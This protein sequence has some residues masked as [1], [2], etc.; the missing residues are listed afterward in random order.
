MGKD[1]ISFAQ[2]RKLPSTSRGGVKRLKTVDEII[3]EVL[4]A[5]S[6][7]PP[8]DSQTAN[9]VLIMESRY[10]LGQGCNNEYIAVGLLM[11]N[12][13]FA[14]VVKIFIN[15]T[16]LL[17]NLDS[18]WINMEKIF[19]MGYDD[20]LEFSFEDRP[21]Y[22]S[23]GDY[24]VVGEVC[25]SVTSGSGEVLRVQQ[26]GQSTI[27]LNDRLVLDILN[28]SDVI[29]AKKD[30]L[31]MLNFNF[32]YDKF[33]KHIVS[34]AK[35][36]DINLEEVSQEHVKTFISCSS[37]LFPANVKLALTECIKYFYD[38]IINDCLKNLS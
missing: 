9:P 17:F 30:S 13:T 31:K 27:Y 28:L 12:G 37:N 23:Y 16:F 2:K 32:V 7:S 10:P 11:E 6:S 35:N 34:T 29:L 36:L 22:Q 5:A 38:S 26:K 20:Y 15:H 14:P 25:D 1:L 21:F 33:I 8:S 18:T 24:S 4:N 3:D 19:R